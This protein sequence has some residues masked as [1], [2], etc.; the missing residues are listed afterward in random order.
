MTVEILEA[1]G[2]EGGRVI[3]ALKGTAGASASAVENRADKDLPAASAWW[4]SFLRGGTVFLDAEAEAAR[5]V[6]SVDAFCGCGGLTLGAVQSAIAV[7]RTLESVAAIDVDGEGLAVHRANFGTKHLFHTNASSLVDWHV[8]GEGGSAS[9]AYPPEI[10]DPILA[11]E[12]GKIDLF[13]AGPPCQG[14]SNLNNRTRREDPR[15]LL[16]LTAVALGV[17]LE[18][19]AIVME[20]VPDVVNDKSDV[21]NTAKA[22][23]KSSGYVWIDS[24]TL[25]TDHLG[26]AQ[27]RKR[28]FL[29]A[30][31]EDARGGE[32]NLKEIASR[33][34]QP[35]RPLSWAI[36]DLLEA[37]GAVRSDIMDTVPATSAENASRIR[38]LFEHDLHELPDLERPDSHK[39]GH[40]Y[41]S[42]Y[43][44][45]WWD[46]PSGTIT[47]GFLTP[48]RGR[49]I[50]PLRPRV[51]T[52]REAARI[53]TFPDTFR[54]VVDP[55][56][57]PSRQAL[58]KWIGD[59]VPPLLG[60]AATLPLMLRL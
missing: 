27:T 55:A 14:H 22:L 53:Q 2:F 41:P 58:Q 5:P 51:I 29:I 7:G 21:V 30:T 28:Y 56:A 12:V 37:K 60:Y 50:H 10:L 40:T 59:A 48:G 35:P 43:G 54:F 46:K 38:H 15:N 45:L 4:Q 3:R 11:D 6:R 52:P 49:H 57:P 8:S 47:T 23:L 13:M 26:G 34:R 25:S 1:Y 31:R 24:G 19:K 33:L 9:F 44:R 36:G 39:N 42:V 18:A 16:Y 17:G 32:A 20:N